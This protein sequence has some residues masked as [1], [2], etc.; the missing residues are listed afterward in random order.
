MHG[1][2]RRNP[3]PAKHGPVDFA[4][5]ET[6]RVGI[7]GVGQPIVGKITAAERSPTRSTGETVD[8]KPESL[9]DYRGKVIAKDL[10]CEQIKSAVA[11][12]LRR[13]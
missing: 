6:A 10:R 1:D 3:Q 2:R 7:G 13:P 9:V 4:S 8:G 12:T 11:E 5:G